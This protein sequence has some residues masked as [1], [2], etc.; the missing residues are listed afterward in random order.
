MKY[1]TELI[2]LFSSL[3]CVVKLK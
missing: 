3:K 2:E 1:Y